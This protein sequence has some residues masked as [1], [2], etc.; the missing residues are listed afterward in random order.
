MVCHDYNILSSYTMALRLKCFQ[1][2]NAIHLY[3]KIKSFI[4]IFLQFFVHSSLKTYWKIFYL[5]RCSNIFNHIQQYLFIF[6]Y[7]TIYLFIY[8]LSVLFPFLP[9][10]VETAF[11]CNLIIHPTGISPSHHYATVRVGWQLTDSSFP[12]AWLCSFNP[13]TIGTPNSVIPIDFVF[14]D[15]LYKVWTMQLLF[16][17]V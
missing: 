16:C 9:L 7:I 1:H 17:S 6:C 5:T 15:I 12:I 10:H 2:I 14:P 8:L 11:G 13:S 3:H 4:H